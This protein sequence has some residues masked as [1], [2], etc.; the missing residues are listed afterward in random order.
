MRLIRTTNFKNEG[1][2]INP[3]HNELIKLH[4]LK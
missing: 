4:N 2:N 1:L 3:S